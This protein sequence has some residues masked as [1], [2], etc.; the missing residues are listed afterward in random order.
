MLKDKKILITGNTGF[1]GTWLSII[2]LKLGANVVG[3]S[4]KI[5]TTPSLYEL[6]NMDNKVKTY[7][8]DIIDINS[9][10]KIL[11]H[12]KPDIVFHLAAQ[13][14]VSKSY[15]EPASTYLTNVVGTLHLYE[16]IR[17]LKLETTVIT[18]TTDKV[19]RDEKFI[20][21]HNLG[22]SENDKLGGYDIYSSSKACVEILTDS[23][24]HTYFNQ[25]DYND[26]HKVKIVTARAGN[27]IGFGDFAE[28]RLIPNCIKAFKEDKQVELKYNSIRPWQYI[29]DCLFGYIS[30]I[31]YLDNNDKYHNAW[32]FGPEENNV[33]VLE[34]VNKLFKLWNLKINNKE[35]NTDMIKINSIDKFW[36]NETEILKLDSN[37]AKKELNFLPKYNIDKILE[38]T[39]E[40]YKNYYNS[41]MIF[42][43]CLNDIDSYLESIKN[44]GESNV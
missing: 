3:I 6:C 36:F 35:I 20:I 8:N 44:G 7:F 31:E 37:L 26:K 15:Q 33:T 2:L 41:N 29:L 43:L 4:D 12:E 28:F 27:V 14:L 18:I 11:E 25:F 5:P 42:D 16:A 24:R 9:I 23:Y 10:M 38:V 17:I 22:Y 21:N 13:A 1:K 32:N 30:L 19:Y 39:V 34:L 40:M